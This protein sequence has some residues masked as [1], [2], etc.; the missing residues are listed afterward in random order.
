MTDLPTADDREPTDLTTAQ[1][2]ADLQDACR[3]VDVGGMAVRIRG[4]GVLSDEGHEALTALVNVARAQMAATPAPALMR[5]PTCGPHATEPHPRQPGDRCANCK[6]HA[7]GLPRIEG[8]VVDTAPAWPLDESRDLSIPMAADSCPGFKEG[9]GD[10]CV[11]CGDALRWH[12]PEPET[13]LRDR[14]AEALEAADYRPDMRRG[15]LADA[16]MPVRDAEL[17]RLRAEV[18]TADQI[19]A[20]VQADRDASTARLDF[21]HQ[22]TLPDLRRRA[23]SDAETIKRWRKRAETAEAAVE[24]V[25]RLC[26]LTIAHSIRVHAVAQARDTLAAIDSTDQP[27]T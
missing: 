22:N 14:Y 24:Q 6:T 21:A 1:R 15:D 11:R 2:E 23:D 18:A 10:L 4:T 3:T 27:T 26:D 8:P 9:P 12:A 20:E 25:R 13:G 19:L 5:C 7:P 17:E 16:L